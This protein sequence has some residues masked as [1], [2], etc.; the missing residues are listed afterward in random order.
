MNISSRFAA[1][2]ALVLLCIPGN[3]LGNVDFSSEEEVAIVCFLEG[4]AWLYAQGEIE[5]HE[6]VLFQW[7]ESGV[8][9]ETGENA[10][11]I[12]AFANGDRYEV[13]EASKVQI[14]VNDFKSR[15]GSIKKLKPAPIM[16]RIA[17]ITQES[18]PGNRL[19]GIRL[20]G[21]KK[22]ISGLYPNE[23]AAALADQAVLTFLPLEGINK[24]KVKIEDEKGDELFSVETASPEV[25]VSKGI[26]RPGAVYYWQV[27]ALAKDMPSAVSYATF[28]T[29][30]EENAL[31]R[32]SFKAQAFESGDGT[33]LLLLAQLETTLGL[34][35]EACET[36]REALAL[37]PD[38][39]KIKKAMSD[40]GCKE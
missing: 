13:G 40:I 1:S 11:V 6:I 5:R 31:L 22:E 10:K 30:S 23:G 27:R 18:K 15:D 3:L 38:N 28:S 25:V 35:R 7:I 14:G 24:Y 33:D 12:L 19:G 21:P 29:V 34:I 8:I 37:F 9:V 2:L 36:L 20:R 39:E 16:P 4:K 32:N 26:L 17:A